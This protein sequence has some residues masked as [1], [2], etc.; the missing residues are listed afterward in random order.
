MV[1]NFIFSLLTL[2][3]M[4]SCIEFLLVTIYIIGP[5]VH[6]PASIISIAKKYYYL[7]GRKLDQYQCGRHDKNLF[8]KYKEGSC[9]V[10]NLEFTTNLS[11][12]SFGVR[13]TEKSLKSDLDVVFI[14]DSH[15]QG[16]GMSTDERFSG[17][18]ANS[19]GLSTVNLGISSYGTVREMKNL[20]YK[21]P[22]L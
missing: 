1:K 2:L 18:V 14:G 12:N 4:L 15:T 13:D 20:E 8:Y 19:S 10:K 16:W 11:I 3:I 5:K 17:I 9:E 22:L 7:N 21:L 6:L